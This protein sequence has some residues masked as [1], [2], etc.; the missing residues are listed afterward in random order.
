MVAI[1]TWNWGFFSL[2]PLY[3]LSPTL[4]QS[5]RF[6]PSL[7]FSPFF[8]AVFHWNPLRY[9]FTGPI[10]YQLGFAEAHKSPCWCRITWCMYMH[11][12]KACDTIAGYSFAHFSLIRAVQHWQSVPCN[13]RFLRSWQL[14]FF[15]SGINREL[16]SFSLCMY[17]GEQL[18]IT[19][20]LF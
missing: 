11:P 6:S 16:F 3:Q 9:T 5:I 19:I 8:L 12:S 7:C 1:L 4:Y 20:F 14:A 13:L 10:F 2:I 17:K 15:S 18:L